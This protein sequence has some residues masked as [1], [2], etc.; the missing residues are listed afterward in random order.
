M[1]VFIIKS[2]EFRFKT[3]RMVQDLRAG[4]SFVIMHYKDVLG[5]ITPEVPEKIRKKVGVGE[6]ARFPEVR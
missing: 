1:A 6:G 5:Y 3:S 2:T 4:H